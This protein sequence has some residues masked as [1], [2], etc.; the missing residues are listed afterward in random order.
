MSNQP[1]L[2]QEQI[3][4]IWTDQSEAGKRLRAAR[5]AGPAAAL[6]ELKKQVEAH[7]DDLKVQE[8]L[9]IE[10]KEKFKL[11]RLKNPKLQMA[12]K[13]GC[14]YIWRSRQVDS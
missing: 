11:L 7:T 12:V 3:N 14:Q 13:F 8:A 4:L 6:A 5:E 9:S 10:L 2:T 1:T